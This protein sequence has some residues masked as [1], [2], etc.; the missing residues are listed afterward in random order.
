MSVKQISRHGLREGVFAIIVSLLVVG[1]L[2]VPGAKAAS[3]DFSLTIVPGA[4]TI[5]AGSSQ[6]FTVT[7]TSENG[8]AGTINV[9]ISG[10]VPLVSN[11]PTFHLT[12]YDIPVSPTMPN[13]TAYLTA[14][15]IPG[16]PKTTYTIT[17]RGKDITG[18]H[19][20]G[21]THTTT[22]TLTVR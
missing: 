22:F 10:V 13:G 18:G 5:S 21:L 11:G 3:P 6:R 20:Y 8:L 2:A 7:V 16:T 19:Q 1:A 12:R 14:F 15:T 9:G 17:V 4:A